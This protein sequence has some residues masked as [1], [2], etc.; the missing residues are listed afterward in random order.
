MKLLSYD[1]MPKDHLLFM[2]ERYK[3]PR[4]GETD[5]RWLV[6]VRAAVGRGEILL[7]RGVTL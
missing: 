6:R 2:P 7:V 1:W 3:Q 4:P 5:E